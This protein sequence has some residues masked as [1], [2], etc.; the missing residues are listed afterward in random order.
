MYVKLSDMIER[1][2]ER[3]GSYLEKILADKIYRNRENYVYI[4]GG[5][6]TAFICVSDNNFINGLFVDPDF[7]GNVIGRRL[8]RYIKT[9]DVLRLNIYA[10]SRKMFNFASSEGFMIN[11]ALLC[12]PG[13]FF[14]WNKS[15]LYTG[16]V[17]GLT[18]NRYIRGITVKKLKALIYIANAYTPAGQ[19]KIFA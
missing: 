19:V 9:Y 8:A 18:L 11:G 3:T 6:I 7:R 2:K 4:D 14:F 5:R 10:K 12:L 16:T 1:Y 15:D 17:S 13:L